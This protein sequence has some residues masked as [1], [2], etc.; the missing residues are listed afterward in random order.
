[1][2]TV[3]VDT[4]DWAN[5]ATGMNV[6]TTIVD[7]QI[8]PVGGLLG[9]FDLTAYNS[10]LV[11]S[12]P[13]ITGA[14]I[15]I[16]DSAS[17]QA[18]A[19]L[20]TPPDPLGIS[21]NPMLI[22]LSG[23]LVQLSNSG[24]DTLQVWLAGSTRN[25]D[26]VQPFIRWLDVDPLALPSAAYSGTKDLGYGS[27]SGM[28]F[29]EFTISGT[30]AGIFQVVTKSGTMQIADSSEMHTSPSGGGKT[31]FREWI[32]PR[33]LWKMQFV[34]TTAATGIIRAQTVYR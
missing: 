18:V 3:P 20:T 4:P 32:A 25:I 2:T 16:F 34:V 14:D 15:V 24:V 9:P 29:S 27:G 28:A 17:G 5:P 11:W 13:S 22:P 33:N 30:L 8:I 6:V 26:E 1:M 23:S 10:A 12:Q 21:L 31:L 19:E 7:G